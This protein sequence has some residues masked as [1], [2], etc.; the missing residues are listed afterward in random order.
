[1]LFGMP[2]SK[3]ALN[4]KKV[5]KHLSELVSNVYHTFPSY[6]EIIVIIIIIIIILIVI[7]IIVIIIII[8]IIITKRE[9]KSN[10]K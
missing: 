8:I 4:N 6:R 3:Y 5:L 1:M 2:I 10:K 7:I 9:Y